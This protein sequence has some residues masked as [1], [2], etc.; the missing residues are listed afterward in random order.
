M[1]TIHKCVTEILMRKEQIM[2]GKC[3]PSLRQKTLENLKWCNLSQTDKDCITEVFKRYEETQREKEQTM[4]DNDVIKALECCAND[5]CHTSECPVF[6]G[7]TNEDCRNELIKSALD[8]IN[9]LQKDKEYYKNNRNEYQDKVMF[10]SKQCDEL[11]EENSRQKA[12]KEA[13]INGQETLQKY[14]AEQK[15]EIER[16]QKAGEE[17]VSCFNRMESLYNIKCMEL[18][19]AKKQAITDIVELTHRACAKCGQ[20]DKFNKAVFLNIVDQ[21]AKEMKEG[22]NNA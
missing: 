8:L 5:Y 18:K 4:T 6:N 19:V 10:I 9:R 13:L 7:T 14:I 2:A 17:A 1:P 22:V 11:Q 3:R 21:I 16:L 20:K 12:E 15:A